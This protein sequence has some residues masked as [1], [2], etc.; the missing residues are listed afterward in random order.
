MTGIDGGTLRE[1]RRSRG[2][3][4]PALAR[5]L[6]RAAGDDTLPVHDALV[7][8]IRRWEREGL[9]T[10]RYELLYR[11]ALTAPPPGTEA[12]AAAPPPHPLDT[13]TQPW[14][15]AD[16][17]TRSS[18]SI[19]AVGFIEEAV[20]SLAARYPFTPPA[21]L[22]PGVQSML[23]AVNDAL[24]RSQP[25]NVRARCVR[26]AG[27]LCGVAGQ[28]ADDTGRPDKSAAWFSAAGLA[29][30]E[31][32]D[33]DM[34]GWA[35]ALRSIGCHFRGEYAE[36]TVLLDRARAAAL[37]SA[38]RRR[39]WLAALSARAQAAV[40]SQRRGITA[41]K[42][43]VMRTVDDAHGW[44]EAAGPPTD[45]DFF[46]EP[47]L[48]GMAGTTLLLLGDTDGA[49]AHI[50][51]ALAGRDSGDVKGRALL[52]LDLAEC[53]AASREPEEAAGLAVRAVGMTG[54]GTVLP[55]VARAAAVRRALEP[56][57]RTRAVAELGGCLADI[58]VTGTEG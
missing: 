23:R 46:D 34:A 29:A 41:S 9:R 10:E 58:T 3:D 43:D 14:E 16:T 48:A 28:L 15:L 24:G 32:G 11:K 56:W 45:T 57:S 37:S 22:I 12:A 17:I 18:L 44:L 7:R 39:A 8:M 31:T 19:T 54:T 35:L 52:T 55:V 20:T 25:L 49:K 33:L 40:A 13:A 47:R 53:M 5:E 50:G 36:S 26:L 42:S 51:E 1:W 30:A 38:P 2:W 6:R 21:D 27:V 4:V